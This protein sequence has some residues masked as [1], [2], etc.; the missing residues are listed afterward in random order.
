MKITA[1]QLRQMINEEARKISRA[2]KIRLTE[3]PRTQDDR[4]YKI[5]KQAIVQGEGWIDPDDVQRQWDDMGKTRG[6]GDMPHDELLVRL[7]DDGLLGDESMFDEY[8][9][10]LDSDKFTADAAGVEKFGSANAQQSVPNVTGNPSTALGMVEFLR[11]WAN[12]G[13]MIHQQIYKLIDSY[14]S[15]ADI[16]ASLRSSPESEI[17]EF[18]ELASSTNPSALSQAIKILDSNSQTSGN[19]VEGIITMLEILELAKVL[20]QY[21]DADI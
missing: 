7:G 10:P 6:F 3:S 21:G 14:E 19:E 1:N 2:R 20:A 8:G 9:A 18:E 11:D 12:L 13:G 5:F 17:S 15:Y 16:P 4:D